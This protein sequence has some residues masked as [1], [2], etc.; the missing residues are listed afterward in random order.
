MA[1][2]HYEERGADYFRVF[3]KV[4]DVGGFREMR[5]DCLENVIFAGHVVGFWGY[6][7]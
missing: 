7:A 4:I 5:V 3:A 1:A 6:W 2:L